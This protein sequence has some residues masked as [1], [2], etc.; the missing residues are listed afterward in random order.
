M[1]RYT[2]D[3]TKVND[4]LDNAGGVCSS[5]E[6]TGLEIQKAVRAISQARKANLVESFVENKEKL[7]GLSTNAVDAIK[8]ICTTITN[9]VNQ[10][11]DYQDAEWYIKLFA[12]FGMFGR[13]LFEGFFGVG[14]GLVDGL[15]SVVAWGGSK[16]GAD[17][18]AIQEFVAFDTFG[19][20]GDKFG[21]YEFKIGDESFS[22][23]K[24]SVF[25]ENSTA[26]NII[27]GIGTMAGYFA[28][29]TVSGGIVT[30]LATGYLADLGMTTQAHMNSGKSFEESFSSGTKEAVKGAAFEVVLGGLIRSYAKAGKEALGVVDDVG[31]KG[32]GTVDD[33]DDSVR[34]M[35][36]SV[37]GVDGTGKLK[38]IGDIDEIGTSTRSS[39]GK[40]ASGRDIYKYDGYDVVASDAKNATNPSKNIKSKQTLD[41]VDPTDSSKKVGEIVVETK[42]DGSVIKTTK[43]VN[44]DT[45]KTINETKMFA[46]KSGETT[47]TITKDYTSGGKKADTTTII[48]KT[49]DNKFVKT[50]ETKS[51]IK[52]KVTSTEKIEVTKD[53][54]SGTTTIKSETFDGK[55]KG[56]GTVKKHTSKVSETTET[57]SS[58]DV[59]TRVS[60][61]YDANGKV[62]STTTD[63]IS[64]FGS[65]DINI[66]RSVDESGKVVS[67]ADINIKKT[68]SGDIDDIDIA[69]TDLDA[70]G[71]VKGTTE[72]YSKY[73]DGKVK[74]S[75]ITEFDDAGNIKV[76]RV[77]EVTDFTKSADA[78]ISTETIHSK[79]TSGGVTDEITYKR[80][81]SSKTGKTIDVTSTKVD[82]DATTGV[83]TTIE[84]S[85]NGHGVVNKRV[86]SSVDASGARTGDEV[87][88][89]V[90]RQGYQRKE[91]YDSTGNKTSTTV[92]LASGKEST[93]PL[94]IARTQTATVKGKHTHFINDSY[95]TG[96]K[97]N[98]IVSKYDDFADRITTGFRNVGDEAHD[99][100]ASH[101]ATKWPTK[102]Y[103]KVSTGI[104]NLVSD[105]PNISRGLGLAGTVGYGLYD[106]AL[107]DNSI[108][109][110]SNDAFVDSQTDSKAYD[111]LV[112]E[113]ESLETTKNESEDKKDL[114]EDPLDNGENTQNRED[115]SSDNALTESIDDDTS[116][117]TSTPG[118][119]TSSSDGD[120]SSS[121][122]TPGGDSSSSTSTPDGDSSSSDDN[123]SLDDNKDTESEK[124][125]LVEEEDK[126]DEEKDDGS[127]DKTPQQNPDGDDSEK[128][129][130]EE[131]SEPENQQPT[132]P[133][134]STPQP[135]PN[136]TP[137]PSPTPSYPSYT[138]PSVP[139][140]SEPS[141]PSVEDTPI[142]YEELEV[143]DDGLD[144]G[145]DSSLLEDSELTEDGLYTIPT[146]IEPTEEPSDNDGGSSVGPILTGLGLAGAAGV[147]AKIFLDKKKERE[148][149][150]EEDDDEDEIIADEWNEDNDSFDFMNEEDSPFDYQD[151]EA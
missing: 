110:M 57:L 105:H 82:V 64:K 114:Y 60:K 27:E 15:A 120:S 80:D 55:L 131:V 116:S 42:T 31:T 16:F 67:E 46:D 151:Q 143:L 7:N 5:L 89:T 63:N 111:K 133:E 54:T 19:T 81:I 24:Y 106:N 108:I 92:T 96:N 113:T 12:S 68:A 28:L 94:S 13:K 98:K 37:T 145:D 109:S 87:I 41:I 71:N 130:D 14:E 107:K 1:S 43:K 119:D 48:E 85:A 22:I 78:K 146:P 50:T 2:Y 69:R 77:D 66:S 17:T 104:S 72:S 124:D 70:G 83:K 25:S 112:K 75:R 21:N 45:G 8:E 20:L 99:W 62:A 147:G 34:S 126:V 121:T 135:T 149:S 132:Q 4:F 6:E 73:S 93:N 86:T 33:L 102:L 90:N 141:T 36:K 137:T 30:D 148:L 44:P 122:S 101:K 123:S 144:E 79:T 138:T 32:L 74:E 10:I 136:P 18:T 56:D 84:N 142:D 95:I 58:G 140:P 9:V 47:K 76:E 117:S 11:K 139:T 59:Q 134:Q 118:S 29:G 61:T 128:K 38:N 3:E 35:Q 129:P 97:V 53:P 40:T 125:D 65:D 51:T 23:N 100:L 26:A 88:E 39:V 91:V 49:D 127:E 115:P 103:D 52:N 150:D